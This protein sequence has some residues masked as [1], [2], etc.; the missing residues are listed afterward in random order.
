MSFRYMEESGFTAV[1]AHRSREE[2]KSD[3][4]IDGLI[5]RH[6]VVLTKTNGDLR[7]R[8]AALAGQVELSRDALAKMKSDLQNKQLT[9]DFKVQELQ[10][11]LE[12]LRRESGSLDSLI[13][14]SV[15]EKGM[16]SSNLCLLTMSIEQL[17]NR[18]KQ[19]CRLQVGYTTAW[20]S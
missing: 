16:K 1:E 6:D 15:D 14:S 17:L 19:T 9:L 12:Q 11:V 4:E 10:L 5:R 20:I 8:A 7:E 3:V 2:V 13:R 18:A